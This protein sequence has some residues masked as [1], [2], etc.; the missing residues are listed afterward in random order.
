MSFV[1]TYLLRFIGIFDMISLFERFFPNRQRYLVKG[2]S[3]Y[4]G[5]GINAYWEFSG[6]TF[7]HLIQNSKVLLFY[8]RKN[9]VST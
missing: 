7:Y 1:L 8:F 4:I 5:K 3:K 9:K 6:V 2:L